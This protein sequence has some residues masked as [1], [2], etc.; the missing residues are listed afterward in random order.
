MPLPLRLPLSPEQDLVPYTGLKPLQFEGVH[1]LSFMHLT[2]VEFLSRR[3]K[4]TGGNILEIGSASGATV[5]ALLHACPEARATCVDKFYNFTEDAV[6]D[7]GEAHLRDWF[8]NCLA[9]D[10]RMSLI[11]G[12]FHKVLDWSRFADFNLILLDA[13]HSFSAAAQ[14]LLQLWLLMYQRRSATIG[15]FIPTLTA[16]PVL[17]LHD[18]GTPH[19]PGVTK[20]VDI[21][22]K[23]QV[24]PLYETEI[25]CE[26]F[27][28]QVTT[29]E[30]LVELRFR[31]SDA[32]NMFVW[33]AVFQYVQTEV[34]ND[35]AGDSTGV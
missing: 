22:C 13:D 3:L 33:Y 23:R 21:L 31:D 17:I 9:T 20:A 34:T 18:Y 24:I 28:E 4:E 30:S 12:D 11:I 32:L 15:S 26:P 6:N 8:R 27:F 16:D 19:W 29:C 7:S 10:R 14:D 2:E 35:P 1:G 5:A 25:I